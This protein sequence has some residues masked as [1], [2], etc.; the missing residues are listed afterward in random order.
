MLV[1][2]LKMSKV[3]FI[4]KKNGH[5]WRI[6]PYPAG[7]LCVH[8]TLFMVTFYLGLGDFPGSSAGKES[9]YNSGDPSSITGSGRLAGEGIG[10]QFQYS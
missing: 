1:S 10:Y 4:L 3:R 7:H 9:A 6:D 8:F 2:I 5:K